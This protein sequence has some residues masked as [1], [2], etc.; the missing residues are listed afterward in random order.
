M[1]HWTVMLIADMVQYGGT[2]PRE[3]SVR[4]L[5]GKGQPG[6]RGIVDLCM[7]KKEIA[8]CMIKKA[9]DLKV[10][11]V[12]VKRMDA[13]EKS[14]EE[15]RKAMF[16]GSA[17]WVGTLP[18]SAQ[19]GE[20][21]FDNK[22]DEV[23]KQAKNGGH[24]MEE[25][26]TRSPVKEKMDE[27]VAALE[28]EGDGRP[29][30]DM[31]K[32]GIDVEDIDLSDEEDGGMML[33][34]ISA[35]KMDDKE[36][37][38]AQWVTYAKNLVDRY[39][40]LHG[41]PGS[42]S[43]VAQLL[44]ADPLSQKVTGK[45]EY[46]LVLYDVTR[47]GE[48]SSRPHLRPPPLRDEHLKRCIKGALEGLQPAQNVLPQIPEKAAFFFIDRNL[49][50]AGNASKAFVDDGGK[51]IPK[52]KTQL[53]VLTTEQSERQVKARVKGIATLS[54]MLSM[55]VF[56]QK[57]LEVVAK[58]HL[59][60]PGSTASDCLG[61][62]E[63]TPPESLWKVKHASKSDLLGKALIAVGGTVDGDPGPEVDPGP[64]PSSMVPFCWHGLPT[65]FYEELHH[66]F[67][68]AGWVD[69]TASDPVLPMTAIRLRKSYFGLCHTPE[70]KELL[71]KQLAN[72]VFR[73]M[74]HPSDPLF[75]QG[76]RDALPESMRISAAPKAKAKA[77][78]NAKDKKE[79]DAE[80]KENQKDK[81]K[82]NEKGKDANNKPKDN[83]KEA[84]SEQKQNL[85]DK[86]RSLDSSTPA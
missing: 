32:K 68:G 71:E 75:E 53:Y 7:C 69:L 15:Y 23:I 70:H 54:T 26:L 41:D 31:E 2:I 10:S 52:V 20:L 80:A 61:P 56:S 51:V 55:N 22:Y 16:K 9:R 63:R 6:G 29:A 74:Q 11:E 30:P 33:P 57:T 76:L 19:K 38:L 60:V 27:F 24:S 46:V 25:A 48:A 13:W 8:W 44:R 84:S 4:K 64:K 43:G 79:Q 40:N 58:D 14:P 81:E 49:G 3:L 37:V 83:K 62:F 72:Q 18:D 21:V 35:K 66:S 50:S 47:A 1:I 5:S 65:E 85:L 12:A 59:H 39:V 73:A 42:V 78:T 17:S 77:N 36:G 34:G 28:A 82:D 67:S 45:Q 86:L